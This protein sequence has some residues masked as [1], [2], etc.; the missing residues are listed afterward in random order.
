M[1]FTDTEQAILDKLPLE[2]QGIFSVHP[3]VAENYLD[4]IALPALPEGKPLPLVEFYYNAKPDP[5][6]SVKD[7]V[8]LPG[9]SQSEAV[10]ILEAMGEDGLIWLKVLG[11]VLIRR[12]DWSNLPELSAVAA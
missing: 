2:V 7:S 1:K 8:A 11:H 4:A 6:L 5:V 10:E 3:S 12:T 9:T